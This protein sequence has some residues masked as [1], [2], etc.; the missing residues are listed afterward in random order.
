MT[1]LTKLIG[2]YIITLIISTTLLNNVSGES[3]TVSNINGVPILNSIKEINVKKIVENATSQSDDDTLSY[4]TKDDIKR[5]PRAVI[6]MLG[7]IAACL[8]ICCLPWCHSSITKSCEEQKSR[9]GRR[10]G[11]RIDYV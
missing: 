10:S 1:P 3:I 7:L 5:L 11:M 9:V 6:S 4:V 8:F 2:F